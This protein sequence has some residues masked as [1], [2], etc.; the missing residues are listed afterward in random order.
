MM[1][2]AFYLPPRGL[3]MSFF[4][5]FSQHIGGFTYNHSKIGYGCK[6][7]MIFIQLLEVVAFN[8]FLNLL[9]I[10]QYVLQTIFVSN[11]FSHI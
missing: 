4:K 7:D 11:G 8:C 3:R 10:L 1:A 5:L 9:D 6:S 2:H